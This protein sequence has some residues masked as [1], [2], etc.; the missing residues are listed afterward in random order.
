ME[1]ISNIKWGRRKSKPEP[2]KND[3]DEQVRW[4][5]GHFWHTT[6]KKEKRDR[7]AIMETVYD[8][9][10]VD[11]HVEKKNDNDV[12]LSIES[13]TAKALAFIRQMTN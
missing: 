1:L 12:P 8:D 5:D 9:D 10:L 4:F 13:E 3:D 7:L 6:S 11:G 2:P